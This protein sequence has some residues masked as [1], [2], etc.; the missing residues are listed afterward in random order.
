MGEV[1]ALVHPSD[2]VEALALRAK[3][4]ALIAAALNHQPSAPKSLAIVP[5]DAGAAEG[6]ALALSTV[7]K[8]AGSIG[9]IVVA[10]PEA[11]GLFR[12]AKGGKRI[13]KYP[14]I[15]IVHVAEQTRPFAVRCAK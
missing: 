15:A 8:E 10:G 6:L 13:L 11:I 14:D 9:W 12:L 2:D 7:V 4:S 1:T 5:L 3:G